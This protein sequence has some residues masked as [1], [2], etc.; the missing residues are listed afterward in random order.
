MAK[1]ETKKQVEMAYEH[2]KTNIDIKCSKTCQ[3]CPYR[4][5]AK[6]NDKVTFGTG[7]IFSNVIFVLPTYD[8]KSKIGYDSIISLLADAYKV[9]MGN[10]MFDEVYITRL[11]KC[12]NFSHHDL[13]QSAISPCSEFLIY[14][15]TRL[16]AKHVVFFGS[17]YDDYIANNDTVG[18]Y[19]PNKIIHKAYSPAVLYYDNPVTRNNLFNQIKSVINYGRF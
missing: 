2:I 5:Y 7:S 14:E 11:V 8:V 18:M 13:Y 10:S 6:D 17:A 16:H 9:E 3:N 1:K 12:S 15:L 19:I 4:M